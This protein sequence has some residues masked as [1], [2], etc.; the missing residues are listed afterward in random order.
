MILV[1]HWAVKSL[2]LNRLAE[3][4]SISLSVDDRK[5]FRLLRYRCN[6]PSPSPESKVQGSQNATKGPSC[7]EEWCD[8]CP[9]AAEGLLGVY[10]LGQDVP[11]NTLEAHDAD[12]SVSMAKTVHELIKRA[13]SDPEGVIDQSSYEDI[14]ANI[15]HFASDQGPS[16]NR[17]G[18]VLASDGLLANLVYCSFDAAH[19]VRIGCKDP[20]Q[21]LPGFETQWKQLFGGKEALLPSIQNSEVWTA[22]LLAAQ[23]KVLEVYGKQGSL[24]KTIKTFSF[25]PQRFDSSASPL[26][27]YCSLIRAIAVLC[28][29]QAADAP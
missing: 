14:K 3:A 8:T 7:L 28:G 13:C 23:N 25:A 2:R 5:D 9:L 11:E 1:M 24:E 27:K 26:L 15:R 20:L 10:R 18:K 4:K 21:A 12:K 6:L 17:C 29:M 22:K 19:Q 16:V